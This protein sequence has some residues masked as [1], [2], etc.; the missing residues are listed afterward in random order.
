M[1][2]QGR[3]VTLGRNEATP[4]RTG[5]APAAKR[6]ILPAPALLMP[7]DDGVTLAG[8][9]GLVW[10]P[11][12]EAAGYWLEVAVDPD[13]ARMVESRWGI[14]GT[15]HP[16]DALPIGECCWRVVALDRFGVPG[17]RSEVRHL[18]V[19]TDTAPPFIG[20]TET[21]DGA[22]LRRSPIRWRG[23]SAPGAALTID[24][25]P[26][27]L[28]A[29]GRF[30]ITVAAV[31][32]DNLVPLEAVD[33]A[34]NRTVHERRFVLMPDRAAAVRF[35]ESLPREG[36]ERFVSARPSLA[37]SGVTEAHVEL[38]VKAADAASASAR[39]AMRKGASD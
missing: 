26:V 22:V 28:D 14:K 20:V 30:D 17:E 25:R 16:T 37:L 29:E 39:S 10:A 24:G 1:A 19:R 35:D 23:E 13:F 4:V 33:G 6:P 11:I 21:E 5:Q 38:R 15:G 7:P 36:V 9:P 8:G 32:G 12:E 18:L 3:S 2:A 34:G 27:P 31:E